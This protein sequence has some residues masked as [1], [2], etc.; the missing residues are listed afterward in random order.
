MTRPVVLTYHALGSFPLSED[1]NHLY[2]SPDVFEAQIAY[3]AAHRRPATLHEVVAG[4][5]TRASVAVTFDDGYRSVLTVAA[6]ILARHRVPATVFV[7]TMWIGGANEWDTPSSSGLGIMSESELVELEGFGITVESHGHAHIDMSEHDEAEIRVD[8]EKSLEVIAGITGRRPRYLAYPYGRH[9]PAA[10][11][12]VESLG[13]AGAFSIDKADGGP[14]ARAREQVTREDGRL[15]FRMKASGAYGPLR[16][17][18]AGAALYE[19]ARP[20][21]RRVLLRRR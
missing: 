8:V 2:L 7:P 15:V 3:L 20:V 14:W 18:R 17:S 19:M 4:G 16:R 21:A 12:A 11:R 6:P 13:L 9:S 10:Q 5:T 1:P